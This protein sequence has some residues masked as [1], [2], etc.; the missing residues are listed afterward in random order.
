MR[1]GVGDYTYSLAKALADAPATRVGVLTSVPA[2]TTSQEG[3]LEV[4]PVMERWSLPEARTAM[5]II[6]QWSPDVVHV[7]YPTQGYRGGRLPRWL[8]LIAFLKKAKVVQTWHESYHSRQFFKLF[9]QSVVPGGLVVVRSNYKELLPAP[10]HWAFWNKQYAFIRNGSPFPRRDL[11]SDEAKAVRERY[12]RGRKRLIVFFGFVNPNKRVELLFDIA[13][14]VSDQIV[15][16]GEVRETRKYHRQIVARA[17]AEPW[18]GKV[19]ITGFV[20]PG[21]AAAL[22]AVADAVILPFEAGGGDWNSSVHA[23]V[24]QT[25]FVITTSLTSRGYDEKR[26]TFFARVDDA[27]AMKAALDAYAGRK[28]GYDPDIDRDE[29][30]DIAEQHR[31]FYDTLMREPRA[32]SRLRAREP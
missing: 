15:I 14:P 12:L 7:Q 4:F 18:A 31:S 1:C 24:I 5:R 17:S 10:L 19:T 2:G 27:Q 11:T 9:L 16:A 29:W 13:N 28:R 32:R 21:E 8:P 26:N 23:A 25:A 3:D 30:K 22:L 20:P 6:G